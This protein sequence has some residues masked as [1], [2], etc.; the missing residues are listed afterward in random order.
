MI[1]SVGMTQTLTDYYA[2]QGDEKH[3]YA[4]G[5]DT[6]S[7]VMKGIEEKIFRR[8]LKSKRGLTH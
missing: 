5:I 8:R 7:G 2:K 4:I 1:A 3:I 6:D